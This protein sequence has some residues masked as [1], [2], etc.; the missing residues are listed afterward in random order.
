MREKIF[1]KQFTGKICLRYDVSIASQQPRS[2]KMKNLNYTALYL[3]ICTRPSGEQIA[4][5]HI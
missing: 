5:R 3:A 4:I 1:K 2:T